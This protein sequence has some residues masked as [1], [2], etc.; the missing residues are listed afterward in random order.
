M[1]ITKQT[2]KQKNKYKVF[3]RNKTPMEEYRVAQEGTT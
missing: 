3:L 2:N 1:F